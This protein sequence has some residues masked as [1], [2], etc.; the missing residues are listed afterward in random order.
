MKKILFIILVLFL[1]LSTVVIFFILNIEDYT[2]NK[3][4]DIPITSPQEKYAS[5]IEVENWSAAYELLEL[6]DEVTAEYNY[7]PKAEVKY[8]LFGKNQ[9]V[10]PYANNEKHFNHKLI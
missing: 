6:Y 9:I 1:I 7:T 2:T 10:A 4:S 3:A 8:K 5:I